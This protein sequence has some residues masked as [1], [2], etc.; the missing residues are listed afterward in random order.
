[1]EVRI[2]LCYG[3]LNS[4]IGH[5][6]TCYNYSGNNGAVRGREWSSCGDLNLLNFFEMVTVY[7]ENP[8]KL[9]YYHI[10]Y[11]YGLRLFYNDEQLTV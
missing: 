10:P 11:V 5:D 4:L 8:I 6:K 9:V 1:M 7:A 2:I 3:I